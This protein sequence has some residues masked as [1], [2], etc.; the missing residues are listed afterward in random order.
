MVVAKLHARAQVQRDQGFIG[1]AGR[2]GA[3]VD[4]RQCRQS[5]RLRC[6]QGQTAVQAP[7]QHAGIVAHLAQPA[8]DGERTYAIGIEQHQ[9]GLAHAHILVVGLDQ[10]AA[11]CVLGARQTAAGIFLGCADITEKECAFRIAGPHG[12]GGRIDHLHLEAAGQRLRCGTHAGRLTRL[13]ITA[14]A[15]VFERQVGQIPA[16]GAV[17]KCEDRIGQAQVDEGLGAEDATGAAGAI[18]HDAGLLARHQGAHTQGQLAIRAT[19]GRRDV[20]FLKFRKRPAVQHHHIFTPVE[21][22]REFGG[23]D[24]GRV[25]HLFDQFPKG[26]GR[27]IHARKQGKAG[28]LPACGAAL[29]HKH[30]GVTQRVQSAR[31]ARRDILPVVVDHQTHGLA[32]CQSQHVQLE[33]AVRQGDAVKQ[34]RLAVLA[35]LAHVEQRNFL[36]V[37]QPRFQCGGFYKTCHGNVGEKVRR[38]GQRHQRRVC[39]PMDMVSQLPFSMS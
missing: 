3:G 36:A 8:G 28:G 19:G 11:R 14:L 16:L 26:F 21:H 2:E 17:F 37:V 1:Q 24:T 27:H 5:H 6:G 29:Q 34:M 32:R 30:L 12:Y 31:G 9:S 15:A 10:L 33:P 39:T 7:V 18:D 20:H 25:I 22:A 23:T 38:S 13:A 35:M 4:G